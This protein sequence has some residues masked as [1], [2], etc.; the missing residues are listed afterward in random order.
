MGRFVC[1]QLLTMAH[2]RMQSIVLTP[3]NRRTSRTFEALCVYRYLQ[4]SPSY[5]LT[6]RHTSPSG[7]YWDDYSLR[8]Y[9]LISRLVPFAYWL[10]SIISFSCNINWCCVRVMS[11]RFSVTTRGSRAAQQEHTGNITRAS[12]TTRKMTSLASDDTASPAD[13]I[14]HN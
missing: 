9:S 13:P 6:P 11:T 12:K 4:C 2:Y 1:Y 7:C 14:N 10:M 5:A 3:E 8:F